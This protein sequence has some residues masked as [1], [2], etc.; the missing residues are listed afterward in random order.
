MAEE[1]APRDERTE[2]AT[3]H[4]LEEARRRGNVPFSREPAQAMVLLAALVWAGW[5]LPGSGP[6]FLMDLSRILERAGEVDPDGHVLAA[7]LLLEPGLDALRLLAPF[8]VLVLLAPW[9]SAFAQRS[10]VLTGQKLAPD[11]GRL[12]PLAGLKRLVSVQNLVEFAKSTLKVVIAIAVVVLLLRREVHAVLAAA[13]A[14]PGEALALLARLVAR[15]LAAVM[16]LSLVIAALDV[17]WQQLSWRRSLKMTR[18]E[19]KDE[20]KSTE[21]NP[22]IKGRLRQLQRERSRRRMLA[23]VP[24]AAVVITNPTHF[25][26]ALGY[27]AEQEPVPRVLAKGQ[28]ALALKIRT[29]A[30]E[31]RV[32]VVEDPPVARMLHKALEIGDIIQPEHYKAVAS[33]VGFVNSRRRRDGSAR[34]SSS[35]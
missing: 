20:L 23:D 19:L 1:G 4:R 21:G 30:E 24:K 9:L 35:P 32:P 33:I 12:N 14:P 25:A 15:V 7:R 8:L 10:V 2:E 5:I 11:L 28:D 6:G 22:E 31:A 17:L 27:D 29:I 16:G 3:P 13:D 26:V 18:Q 34:A